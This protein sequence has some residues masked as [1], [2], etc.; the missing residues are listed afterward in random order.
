M[1]ILGGGKSWQ[2]VVASVAL[3]KRLGREPTIPEFKKYTE[4]LHTDAY[5]ALAKGLEADIHRSFYEEEE[6]QISLI[7]PDPFRN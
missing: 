2:E 6:V 7:L 5:T 3:R 1:S 4:K